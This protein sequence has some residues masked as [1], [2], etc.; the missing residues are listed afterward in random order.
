MEEEEKLPVKQRAANAIEPD[1][2][3]LY[4]K[5]MSAFIKNRLQ[6]IQ[7]DLVAEL[8]KFSNNDSFISVAES[9]SNE[10]FIIHHYHYYSVHNT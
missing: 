10:S 2:E 5:M 9:F 6:S 4:M 7:T 3:H 8:I 1:V